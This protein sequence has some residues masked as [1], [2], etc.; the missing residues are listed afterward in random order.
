M[1]AMCGC[2]ATSSYIIFDKLDNKLYVDSGVASFDNFMKNCVGLIDEIEEMR[3]T[4]SEPYGKLLCQSGAVCL[5]KPSI[6]S[7]LMGLLFQAARD[8]GHDIDKII[9]VTGTSPYI[10]IDEEAIKKGLAHDVQATAECFVDVVKSLE[11]L[12]KECV[13]L[14]EKME[15]LVTQAFEGMGNWTEE[16]MK[17]AEGDFMKMREVGSNAN[18]SKNKLELALKVM[19]DVIEVI[20]SLVKDSATFLQKLVKDKVELEKLYVLAKRIN[21]ESKD[22]LI[23]KEIKGNRH[24]FMKYTEEK[25]MNFEEM[26]GVWKKITGE[27]Y[28]EAGPVKPAPKKEGAGPKKVT[29]AKPGETKKGE[30]EGKKGESSKVTGAE[31]KG[32]EGGKKGE[33]KKEDKYLDKDLNQKVNDLQEEVEELRKSINEIKKERSMMSENN[34]KN[35][36]GDVFKNANAKKDNNAGKNLAVNKSN[37]A[38][39]NLDKSNNTGKNVD[40]SNNDI[41]GDNNAGGNQD[42]NQDN[43]A[44]ADNAGGGD[45]AGAMANAEQDVANI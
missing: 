23:G 8:V 9:T 33:E 15:K 29:A 20:G 18:E 36:G 41:N 6:F 35:V 32:A 5:E 27:E 30:E 28:A 17:K 16:F 3:K 22:T 44:G 11:P 25:Q 26:K 31:K 21:T 37:N 34:S 39:K 19:K 10:G 4:I 38:G 45:N 42:D 43:N 24:C 13:E 14:A 7:C 1:G 40:K 2:G 12:E